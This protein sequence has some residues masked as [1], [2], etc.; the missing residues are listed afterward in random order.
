VK[1]IL[2]IGAT[3]LIA[4]GALVGCSTDADVVSHNLSKD[5]E[6]F[7]I[8]R[9]IVFFNGITDKYLLEIQGYCSIVDANGQLEVTCK[10]GQDRYSKEFLGLSDNVSY[11]IEQLEPVASDPYHYEVIFKPEVII[12]DIKR[13]S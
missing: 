6:Q 2:T 8:N 9:R 4:V 3:F 12:P 5:A 13:P 7:N 11:F 10:R 1:R